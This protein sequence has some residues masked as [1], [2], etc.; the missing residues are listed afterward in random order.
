MDIDSF[1]DGESKGEEKPEENL[2]PAPMPESG[3]MSMSD[4]ISKIR[5]LMNQK[6]YEEAEREYVHAKEAFAELTRKQAEEQHKIYQELEKINM[7]MV[8]GLSVLR[9]ETEQNLHIVKELMDK[10]ADHMTRNELDQAN[11]LYEQVDAIFKKLPDIFPDKKLMLEQDIARLHLSLAS[12]TNT[13]STQDFNNKYGQIRNLLGFAFEHVRKGNSAEANNMYQ[14]IN[15]LYEDLPKGFLYE[16]AMLYQQI[17]KL[18]KSLHP[19]AIKEE[20]PAP[21]A[22]AAEPQPTEDKRGLFR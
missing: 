20:A 22:Q 1:L 2:S 21:E 18:Y 11:K 16:K 12:K 5:E 9:Q 14:Q 4:H 6:K 15:K 8:N 10:I 13:Q 19:G 3:E 17:L 7:D